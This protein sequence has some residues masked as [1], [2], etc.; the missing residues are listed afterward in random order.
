MGAGGRGREIRASS[1]PS[2]PPDW[3]RI[4]LCEAFHVAAGPSISRARRAL[5]WASRGNPELPEVMG[6]SLEQTFTQI[7]HEVGK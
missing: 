5:T 3:G 6:W 4:F 7:S 1:R 2:R